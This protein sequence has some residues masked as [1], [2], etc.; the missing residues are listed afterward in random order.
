ML[1]RR[2]AAPLFGFRVAAPKSKIDL[3]T[4]TLQAEEIYLSKYIT[5]L[6]NNIEQYREQHKNL[7][8]EDESKFWNSIQSKVKGL[9]TALIDGRVLYDAPDDSL[10]KAAERVLST[11]APFDL[12]ESIVSEINALRIER[13]RKRPVRF[14]DASKEQEEPGSQGDGTINKLLDEI[15]EGTT[16]YVEKVEEAETA[17]KKS[18]KENFETHSINAVTSASEIRTSIL[19][20]EGELEKL[21]EI[22]GE[23]ALVINNSI[24]RIQCMLLN[25]PK[26]AR[27]ELEDPKKAITRVEGLMINMDQTTKVLLIKIRKTGEILMK[28]VS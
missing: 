7:S 5:D 28:K 8:V 13:I 17:L 16:K 27:P 3:P 14:F 1:K 9:K 20:L 2:K 6:E 22:S 25:L 12:A 15:S 26:F 24:Q 23:R 11:V 21:T 19:A 10:V 4:S 18:E